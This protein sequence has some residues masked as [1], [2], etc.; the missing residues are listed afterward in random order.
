MYLLHLLVENLNLCHFLFLC[1]RF[2][3]YCCH[4]ICSPS[5]PPPLPPSYDG[6]AKPGCPKPP[7][8]CFEDE[9][10]EDG[11]RVLAVPPLF[12][13]AALLLLLVPPTYLLPPPPPP[14]DE[15]EEGTAGRRA[16]AAPVPAV[17]GEK[18]VVGAEVIMD[19]GT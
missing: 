11:M 1:L 16:T 10:E 15:D 2:S 18:V 4:T 17:R 13:T 14:P 8:I 19:G 9:E 12:P 3:C 7:L 6:T 5:H